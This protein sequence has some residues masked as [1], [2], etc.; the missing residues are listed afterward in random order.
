MKRKILASVSFFIVLGMSALG[1]QSSTLEDLG[2]APGREGFRREAN[3]IVFIV[4]PNPQ[5]TP[6]NI[7]VLGQ[8]LRTV[9]SFELIQTETVTV[10]L[11]EADSTAAVRIRALSLGEDEVNGVPLL[12]E[13]LIFRFQDAPYYDFSMVVDSLRLRLRGQYFS[14]EELVAKMGRVLVSP[15]EYLLSQDSEYVFR[16][17]QEIASQNTILQADLQEAVATLQASL[18]QN[19]FD[20]A[21]AKEELRILR[22][23]LILFN[24]RGVFGSWNDFDRQVADRL[25]AWRSENPTATRKEAEDWLKAQSLEASGKLVQAILVAYFNQIE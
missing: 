4:N 5:I 18:S 23:G 25:V 13:G 2:F 14:E 15:T 6:M 11:R 12:P 21:Q 22:D 20:L 24:T 10:T 7:G 16:L 3:G 19:E 8:L 9:E 17:M 1:A